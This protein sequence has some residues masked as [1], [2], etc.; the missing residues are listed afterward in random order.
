MKRILL[1]TV[2][3]CNLILACNGQDDDSEEGG[4]GG[5]RNERKISSRDRSITAANSYSD[6][7]LDSNSV[8]AY[9]RE[10]KAPDSIA[11]R[12]VSFYNAR[13]YQYAWFATDGL[14]E[15]AR[16]FWNLYDYFV[17]HQNDSSLRDKSFQRRM[18]DLTSEERLLVSADNKNIRRTELQLTEFFIRYMRSNY[19]DGQVKR[20]EM[21]RFIP[22]KKEDALK[23]A[24]SL[25]KKKHK[26]NRY[27]EDVNP[28]YAA[29]KKELG[30]YVQIV[31]QGGWPRVDIAL[32]S[33]KPG[34]SAPQVA[35]LKR[36]LAITGDL[37]YSDTS[38]VFN[39]TLANGI[40]NFQARIGYTPTG[41]LTEQQ[42]KELNVPA[43]DRLRQILMNME[44]MRWMPVA[45]TGNLIV[46]NIPEFVLH[47]YEGDRKAFSMNIVVGKQGS[48]TMMFNGD[49]NQVVFSPYWNVP[50]SIVREEI[51][52]KLAS[53]PGYLESQN[54]EQ[55]GME[56][57]LPKIRQRPGPDNSLGQVK[58]LF[59]NSFNIYFHD[60]NA[61]GLFSK[62]RRAYSHG[63]IRL[64][65]PA[66]MAEYLLR[67]QPEWTPDRI[68]TAMNAGTEKYVRLKKP[69]P[70]V[71]TYYTAWV[72]EYGRLNFRDDIYGHDKD[73][74][75]KMFGGRQL[76]K[77]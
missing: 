7:F 38:S 12:V 10:R 39:D 18:D 54:M 47:V 70:V 76:A 26:D 46:V 11:R 71:I 21:E 74:A 50:P 66:K 60:T 6:L 29:L 2:L 57:D 1:Y 20:K 64:E 15:Q 43:E 17:N 35:A 59:P 34:L 63:C 68:Y 31:Q 16:G 65:E 36:R 56:G 52:P 61:K 72:D 4:I 42:L 73:L 75:G 13:N 45:P 5:S 44:R 51:L 32:K 67:T 48:S 33:L 9:L 23:L 69:V 37:P 49:L 40:R 28:A 53:N 58:F 3:F 27:F 41:K 19:E 22:R 25:L 62:D 8:I 77:K 14:T 24:D 30:R 55:V